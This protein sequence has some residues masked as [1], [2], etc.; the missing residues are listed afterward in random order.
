MHAHANA[1]F[2]PLLV[3]SSAGGTGVG[4]F[5]AGKLDAY[6]PRLDRRL[7]S[8]NGGLVELGRVPAELTALFPE[9]ID[10]Y[11]LTVRGCG[12]RRRRRAAL[13]HRHVLN[14]ILPSP[15]CPAGRCVT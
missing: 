13:A 3:R 14:M 9:S 15:R 11:V 1:S 10:A 5:N 4:R 7:Q 8:E 6:L 2:N 12:A